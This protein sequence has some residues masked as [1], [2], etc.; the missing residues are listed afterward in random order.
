LHL[1]EIDSTRLNEIA[2]IFK[3]LDDHAGVGATIA[4][5]LLAPL[6]PALIPTWDDF[7]AHEYGFPLDAAGYQKFLMITQVIARKAREFWRHRSES[8]TPLEDHLLASGRGW[9]APLVKVIGEWNWLRITR[10][11]P[12]FGDPR[13]RRCRPGMEPVKEQLR[14]LIQDIDAGRVRIRKV[15]NGTSVNVSF[16]TDKGWKLS[17]FNDA[18]HWDF[19]EWAE[20]PKGNTLDYEDI[21]ADPAMDDPQSAR[22]WGILY[23]WEIDPEFPE[24]SE[25]IE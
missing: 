17:V 24:P 18:G 14:Q 22:S 7:I 25:E 10:N 20:D 6:R 21:Y 12:R 15:S 23:H 8:S 3:T 11:T 13:P 19:L 9:N 4:S 16:V 5:H 1:D 2:G